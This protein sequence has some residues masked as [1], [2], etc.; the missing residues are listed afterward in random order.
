MDAIQ[1]NAALIPQRMTTMPL[2]RDLRTNCCIA[3][4]YNSRKYKNQL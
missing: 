3:S 1:I 2:C 4:G